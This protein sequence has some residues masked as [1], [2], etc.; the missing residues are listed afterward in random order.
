LKLTRQT[1]WP[2]DR[3]AWATRSKNR[4]A[5]PCK[6]R[7][8]RQGAAMSNIT[9]RLA[10]VLPLPPGH[11]HQTRPPS[12]PLKSRLDATQLMWV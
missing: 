5:S 7:R 9:A 11:K 1:R 6:N 3:N 2:R 8:P 4:P 12:R 10:S